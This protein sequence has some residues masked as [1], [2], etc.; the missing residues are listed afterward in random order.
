MEREQTIKGNEGTFQ[1]H[2][3]IL[4]LDCSSS[5]MTY[6]CQNWSNYTFKN[7][8]S[9]TWT[10]KH[11]LLRAGMNLVFN[12]K[13]KSIL[14]YLAFTFL[15]EKVCWVGIVH[16]VIIDNWKKKSLEEGLNH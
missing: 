16:W 5:H 11:L 7:G 14:P 4:Y 12:F 3:H 1:G 6:A 15:K 8:F 2:G 9:E 10:K 13:I